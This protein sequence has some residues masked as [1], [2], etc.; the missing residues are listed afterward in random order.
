MPQTPDLMRLLQ[1]IMQKGT[2][3]EFPMRD[4]RQ[5]QM[6]QPPMQAPAGLP[7]PQAQIG[8]NE[9][10]TGPLQALLDPNIMQSIAQALM[11]G[12]GGKG[13]GYM[14]LGAQQQVQQQQERQRQQQ[15]EAEARRVQN[16]QLG[17]GQQQ[18]DISAGREAREARA[19]V[20]RQKTKAEEAPRTR[21]IQ[22]LQIA[23]LEKELAAVPGLEAKDVGDRIAYIDQTGN[24]RFSIRKGLPPQPPTKEPRLVPGQDVPFSPSVMEQKKELATIGKEA[25][26]LSATQ[27]RAK[28]FYTRVRDALPVIEK[29]EP[30]MSP[31]GA[32]YTPDAAGALLSADTQQYIQ[33]KRQFIEAY[34]RQDSGATIREEEFD[35][36]DKTFFR[37][38][39]DKPEVTKR[40][41]EAR[42]VIMKTL[43]EEARIVDEFEPTET[44]ETTVTT[45][46]GTF[47]FP[48]K[49]AADEF[50]RRVGVK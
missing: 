21:K 25:R 23:R 11:L 41:R 18:I 9:R 36:A 10:Q 2:P 12:L 8:P 16:V 3:S 17:Q 35:S 4:P 42:R 20:A 38:P 5:G 46:E 28:R 30:T 22:D 45:Q 15:Q 6:G 39:N 43:Q 19:A 13:G 26:P 32:K 47:T 31:T 49:A 14:A 24:E 40:K 33:G 48:S 37:Q 7:P 34:L 44:E 50:K 29:F 27:E 1:E